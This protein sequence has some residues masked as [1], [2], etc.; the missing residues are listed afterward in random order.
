[1]TT[2][3]KEIADLQAEAA[4][5]LA[6][7]DRLQK[8]TELYPD[9]Q[10]RV[11]RWDKVAYYSKAVNALVTNYD[12]RYNCGCCNDSPLEIWPYL[13][14]PHGRVYSDPPEFRV[15]EKYWMGGDKPYAGWKEEMQ[16]AGI[17]ESI[18]DRVQFHFDAGRQ[19]R[20]EAASDDGVV[21][22]VEPFV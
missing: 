19:R 16:K 11:G 17:P 7:A 22:E 8:L 21:E 14:T 20:I 15:G 3:A 4:K 13:E 12:Q 9:L 18:I 10:K 2:S 5:K 6:E 1:M